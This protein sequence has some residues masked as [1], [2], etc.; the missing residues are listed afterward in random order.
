MP[1]GCLE[2]P[3]TTVHFYSLS[4]WI[5]NWRFEL[6]NWALWALDLANNPEDRLA[7]HCL[8]IELER[9]PNPPNQSLYFQMHSGDIMTRESFL[10][11]MRALDKLNDEF[12]SRVNERRSNDTAQII[13][14]CEDL[15]RLLWFSLRDGGAS[16]R[17][18]DPAFS[19]AL[20]DDWERKLIEAINTGQ[21]ASSSV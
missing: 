4:K 9:R 1:G 5:N 17:Q 18:R 10:A 6:Q 16:L 21:P 20:S 12:V 3:Q 19:R 14:T 15:V 13:V 7:T 11:R 8:V 2:D